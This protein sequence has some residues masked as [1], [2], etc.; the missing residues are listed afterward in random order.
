MPALRARVSR[1]AS[2]GALMPWRCPA[3]STQIQH[4]EH[5]PTPR[6]GRIYRC[7]VCRLELVLDV[8]LQKLVVP[9]LEEKQTGKKEPQRIRKAKT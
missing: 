8:S 5:E 2:V 6:A 3:C 9:P 7:S 1:A 4:N